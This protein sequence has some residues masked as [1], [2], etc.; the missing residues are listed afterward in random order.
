[1]NANAKMIPPK[2]VLKVQ[3]K[4]ALKFLSYLQGENMSKGP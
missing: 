4:D 1:M 2:L 3:Y